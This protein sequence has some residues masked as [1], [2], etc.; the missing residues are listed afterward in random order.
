VSIVE[1]PFKLIEIGVE[2]LHADLV[3]GS[4]DGPLKKAPH[5]L[6]AIGVASEKGFEPGIH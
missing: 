6:D 2:M 1:P 3:I 4:D 5:T